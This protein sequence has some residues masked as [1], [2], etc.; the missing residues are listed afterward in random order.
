MDLHRMREGV[1]RESFITKEDAVKVVALLKKAT[2]W[3][4]KEGCANTD[5][6]ALETTSFEEE[7]KKAA[8]KEIID[9]AWKQYTRRLA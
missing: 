9:W 4:E 2:R 8:K 3:F 5:V 1:L 7:E 6:L